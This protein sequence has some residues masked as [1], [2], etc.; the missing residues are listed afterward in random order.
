MGTVA[1][2]KRRDDVRASWISV[3]RI[4]AFAEILSRNLSGEIRKK[5]QATKTQ[6]DSV[7]GGTR[8]KPLERDY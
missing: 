6:R 3:R 7:F 5:P 8:M 1:I 2:A 4:H